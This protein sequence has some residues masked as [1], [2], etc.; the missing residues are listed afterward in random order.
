MIA[1]AITSKRISGWHFKYDKYPENNKVIVID[2]ELPLSLVD[3]FNERVYSYC[4]KHS[5]ITRKQFN[6]V[7]VHKNLVDHVTYEDKRQ[8]LFNIMEEIPQY[9]FMLVD[10]LSGLCD[11]LDKEGA[12]ELFQN[13]NAKIKGN[14]GIV[15]A[16]NHLNNHGTS[17]GWAGKK[18]EEQGSVTMKLDRNTTH[19]VTI[20]S[21]DKCRL[22]NMPTFDFS[23]K[24]DTV[25]PGPTMPFPVI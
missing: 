1:S 2:T 7:Y 6:D 3:R 23:I 21:S 25:I 4:A 17:R 11:P 18:F 9:S 22:G 20:V 15:F 13:I 12:D 14:G 10:N 19:G 24:D 16:I 8:A 5:K